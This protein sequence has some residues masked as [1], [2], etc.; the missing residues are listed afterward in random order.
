M[1]IRRAGEADV[2][3]ARTLWERFTAEAA[4]TPYPPASFDPALVRDQLALVAE[5]G[6]RAVGIAFANVSSQWFGY[7][8]GLYV[9]PDA[10]RQGIATAL[11]RHVAAELA[12]RGVAHVVLDVDTPNKM[13]RTVYQR[14]GFAEVGRRLATP[15]EDFL[16]RADSGPSG[17]TFG[18][19]HIQSDDFPAIERAVRQFVPRLPGGSEGSLVVPPRNGWIAVYDDVCD[20]DPDQL[21]RLARE[22]SDRLGGVVLALGV[23]QGAVARFILFDRGRIVDEYLSVAEYYGALPPGDVIALQA[24]PRVVA[25]LTGANAASVRAAAVHAESPA[26]LPPAPEVL[27]GLARA[28]GIDGGEHGYDDAPDMPGAVAIPRT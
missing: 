15:V 20:R 14:L 3:T 9:E 23:E 1:K 28:I 2:E 5:D 25:R 11:L 21:R 27:A 4:F 17:P 7:V 8:F 24:N 18:S 26:E 10:R 13:A 22:L 6:E 16:K 12:E 19:I